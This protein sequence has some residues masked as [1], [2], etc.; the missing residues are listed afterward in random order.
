MGM[1]VT[2]LFDA[3]SRLH[4]LNTSISLPQAERLQNIESMERVSI[5]TSQADDCTQAISHI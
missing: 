1:E 3:P 5:P 4:R 2:Y